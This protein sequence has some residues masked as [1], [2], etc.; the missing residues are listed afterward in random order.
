MGAAAATAAALACPPRVVV[1]E[2]TI[3]NE[4]RK[5]VASEYGV[6]EAT[7]ENSDFTGKKRPKT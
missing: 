6:N 3:W 1:A 2:G 4:R 7:F 5:R